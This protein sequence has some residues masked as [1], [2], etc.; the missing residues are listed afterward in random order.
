VFLQ[1]MKEEGWECTALDPDERAVEHAR[2]HVGVR[3]IRGDF[4]SAPQLSLYDLIT[5]NKVL[6]HVADPIAMLQKSRQ[7]L[8][9]GG[10]VY[11]E[12]PDGEAAAVE[13]SGREEFFIEHVCVFSL[14]SLR[15]LVTRAGFATQCIERVHEP[16]GKY[17]LRAFLQLEMKR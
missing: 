11:V 3:A 1:R 7:H 10:V 5:F 15:L 17:T 9:P 12:V 8:R 16:S 14:T 6:E 13:G 2:R 4:L